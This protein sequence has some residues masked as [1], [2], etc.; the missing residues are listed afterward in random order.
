MPGYF[1]PGISHYKATK[2]EKMFTEF[3]S[4]AA[5]R[6]FRLSIKTYFF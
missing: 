6:I 3:I 5:Y 1:Y 2:I 4:F